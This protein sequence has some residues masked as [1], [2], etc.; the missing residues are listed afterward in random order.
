M[1]GRICVGASILVGLLYVIGQWL[2]TGDVR[3]PIFI[4]ILMANG[5]ALY[6]ILLYFIDHFTSSAEAI[7]DSLSDR[8]VS[9]DAKNFI[10]DLF[11]RKRSVATGLVF[12]SLFLVAVLTILQVW[13]GY[14]S[15]RTLLG[16]FLFSTNFITG[17]AVY[18]LFIY[19]K[20][21]LK[22]GNIADIDLWDRSCTVF[23]FLVDTNRYLI[24]AVGYICFMA[25]ISLLFS[26][27]EFSFSLTLF[28]IW[29]LVVLITTFIVPLIPVSRRIRDLKKRHA[30]KLSV[31]RQIEYDRVRDRLASGSN[32]DTSKLD[33]I[34]MLQKEIKSVRVFPPVG[35]KSI[36]TAIFIT[37]LTVLPSLVDFVLKLLEQ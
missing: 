1:A 30:E 14:R 3:D 22:L 31:Q 28:S 24:L 26:V 20:K 35:A 9:F 12:G 10:D 25:M 37:I 13:E 7:S 34:K 33:A 23:K 21:S 2:V 11:D 18:S 29:S 17:M 16:L 15:L 4:G 6:T 36:E 27:F 5:F 32:L 19:Y 8:D